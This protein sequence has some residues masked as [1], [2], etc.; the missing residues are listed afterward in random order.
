VGW[1]DW[2]E[3]PSKIKHRSGHRRSSTHA[4]TVCQPCMA[5]I[6]SCAARTSVPSLRGCGLFAP[7]HALHYAPPRWLGVSCVLFSILCW[8]V[9][10]T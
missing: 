8:L 4:E 9:I 2:G 5:A 1:G 10:V 6:V 7:K 3:D